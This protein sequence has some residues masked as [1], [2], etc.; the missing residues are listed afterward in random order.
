MKGCKRKNIGTRTLLA[1]LWY[2]SKGAR[3]Q[4]ALNTVLGLADVVCQLLWVLACK[5]AIDIATGSAKGSLAYTGTII[6]MLML[7]EIS[8]R[9]ASRWI[10]SVT[11]N[12]V[13]NR[14]R[15][16]V[17]ARLLR[18]DWL[19]LQKHHTGDLVNRLEGDVNGITAL[20]TETIPATFVVM[21]QL[22]A[23]FFLL[24]AMSP[25]LAISIVAILPASLLVSQ[26][27]VRRMRRLNRDVRNSDSRIQSVLQ[28]SLQHKELIKTLE[29][30]GSTEEQ[31]EKLQKQLHTQVTDRT[32]F[33][34]G[35]FTFV[36]LGFAAGYLVAFMWGVDSL[37]EDIITYGTM[38]AYLQLV[39]LIQNPTM[40]LGRYIPGIVSSL[41]AAE[42]LYELEDMPLEMEGCSVMLEGTAGVRFRNVGFRYEDKS[43]RILDKFSF[44]FT[45]GSSTA[46]IG[47]TGAGKTTL[48]RLLVALVSPQDGSIEIYN[49]KET[50]LSSTL[51]RGN[52]VYIPQG[53]SLVSGTIRDNLLMGNPEATEEQMRD[54]LHVACADYV[55]DLPDGMDSEVTERGGGLSEGQAQRIAIARSILR[56]GSILILDEVTS[57]LDEE[58]EHELLRRLTG[59]QTGKTLIFVTHRPAIME[60]CTQVLRIDKIREEE[61]MN[62]ANA[63]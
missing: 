24:F 40:A 63:Q 45:P 57:A 15:L 26:F 44:D 14:M 52:F 12:K 51:T 16:G 46:I 50:H 32:K 47:E 29:Q 35:A 34:L 9:A 41:T 54:A 56:P 22:T 42:R 20:I 21:V 62:Q 28:E 43:R 13:R 2:S 59:R 58:T 11:G 7:A 53:N 10:H 31:L 33:S 37:R 61:Q 36:Q 60:Y 55:L 4:A 25:M 23:S 18:C 30:N 8:S 27:Y 49:E 17:F 48:I 38:A 1:W 3:K 6:G 39:G 19:H 5:H